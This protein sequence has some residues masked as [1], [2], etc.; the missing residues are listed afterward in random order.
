MWPFNK[1]QPETPQPEAPAVDGLFSTHSLGPIVKGE[2]FKMP[3]FP[4]PVGAVAMDS[5]M[6]GSVVHERWP[7]KGGTGSGTA[8][9][10]WYAWQT[11]IGYQACAMIAQHWL[12]HKACAMP[13]KD[14]VRQGWD[15]DGDG[16]DLDQIKKADARLNVSAQL[17]DFCTSARIFGIRVALFSVE[18]TDPDYYEKPFNPDGVTQGSYRGIV[19]IDPFWCYPELTD[20]NLTDPA[21]PGFY[22]P[23]FWTIGNRR[24]H[25]SH[26]CVYVPYAV[27]DFLKSTYRFGG[28]SVPQMAYE[29]VYAAERTANEGPVLAMTKR[30]NTFQAAPGA[31]LDKV[32]EN[33]ATMAEMRDN[34]GVLVHG[35]GEAYGQTDTSLADLDAV[36]MTQYQLVAATAEVPATKLLG[37]S[38]KGFG[39]SGE[40]EEASYREALETIQAQAFDPLLEG[41]YR[42]LVK[43]LGMEGD[44]RIQ[45]A[46][47]DSP[48]AAEFAAIELQ[49]AQA[50]SAYAM[51]GAIDGADIRSIITSDKESPYFNLPESELPDP[52]LEE[53]PLAGAP[54]GTA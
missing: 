18:S 38:P 40:Y 25:H 53:N 41:H 4:Q 14:A 12:I 24:Y 7:L 42:R 31:N 28:L 22:E 1:Q 2:A 50:A 54:D 46:A 6:S 26:L 3:E 9:L 37:T 30:L 15:I 49:K 44:V 19:Q 36:I 48:T 39:A 45:W 21:S 8:V 29:R 33:M 43:S 47:L 51:V 52:E 20:A 27:P 10:G 32:R 17:A 5:E 11:F 13:A 16:L 34:H 23:T 35:Q